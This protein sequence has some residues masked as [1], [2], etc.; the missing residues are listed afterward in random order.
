LFLGKCAVTQAQWAVVAKLPK[1]NRDLNPNP[2]RFKGKD[3][4][5]EQV[6]WEDAIEFCDRLS[7][8]TGRSYRLS[9]EAEWEYACRAGTTTPFYFGPTLS[10]DLANYDGNYTY[11]QGQKGTYREKNTAVGSFPPNG[12]GLYDMHGN[13]WEWCADRWHES[14]KNA[15]AD[16]SVWD[17]GG[18]ENRRVVRGG[19]WNNHPWACR[20]AY[21]D[22]YV[23][24]G[25]DHDLGFRVALS[26][27]RTS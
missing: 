13:V 9:S 16:G 22:R 25:R 3:L 5:V 19:S 26:L 12:F 17:T 10:T 21:R 18:E 7:Q 20:S 1:V 23:R 14:Y 4:P 2:S 24:D 11:G 27:P 8:K 15:P 6:S